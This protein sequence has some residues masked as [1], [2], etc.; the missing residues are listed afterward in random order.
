MLERFSIRYKTAT[1]ALLL[2]LGIGLLVAYSV[3]EDDYRQSEQ[4]LRADAVTT[5]RWLQAT[6]RVPLRLQEDFAVFEILDAPFSGTSGREGLGGRSLQHLLLLDDAGRVLATSH[7]EH[8]RL[9]QSHL[10]QEPQFAAAAARLPALHVG[11]TLLFEVHD[12][13][14]GFYALLAVGEHGVKY[15]NLVL[16]YSA[17]PMRERFQHRVRSVSTFI[18][19]V[20]LLIGMLALW[21]TRRVTQPLHNL[22]R[23]VLAVG[24]RHALEMET[25]PDIADEVRQLRHSFRQL[26]HALQTAAITNR[27]LSRRER[28]ALAALEH[29][30]QGIFMTDLEGHIVYANQAFERNSG[31]ARA[32]VLGKNPRILKSGKTPAE[33]YAQMWAALGQG[34]SWQGELFN[35]RSDGSEY[36]ERVTIS[37]VRIDDERVSHYLA[38]QEDITEQRAAAAI[39]YQAEHDALTGLP[40]RVLLQDRL[41]QTLNLAARNSEPFAVLFMDIDHFKEINDLQG[42][43]IGDVLLKQVAERLSG[44][45]RATDTVCRWGGD[46]FVL[47][48]HPLGGE[49]VAEKVAEKILDAMQKS[50]PLPTGEPLHTTCSVGI[51]L[52]PAHGSTADV[53]LRHADMAM[54][55]AKQSGRN[56]QALFDDRL[57]SQLQHRVSLQEELAQALQSGQFVLYYQPQ[58]ASQDGTLSGVEALIRWQHPTRGLVAPDAFIGHAEASGQILEIGAWVLDEACAQMQRW[59]DAGLHVPRMAVNVSV[60]PLLSG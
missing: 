41:T 7:P 15:A 33:V 20:A 56:Q 57:Q 50:F 23:D 16:D 46:E 29:S 10:E 55:H 13:I 45:L 58:Y 52:Y 53:L 27:Q 51:A 3:L 11:E 48:L 21:L 43:H 30:T 14:G 54:Y 47:L 5:A 40:N 44:V 19:L 8:L 60:R 9:G 25:G 4:E 17:L 39:R 31:F 6:L 1:V 26:D 37:P 38:V 34:K 35:R 42:H 24:K 49:Q 2:V 32:Q 18:L 36:V 22:N 59:R 12:E 28:L